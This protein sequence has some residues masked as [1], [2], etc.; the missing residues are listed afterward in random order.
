MTIARKILLAAILSLCSIV[1][2][3]AGTGWYVDLNN[4]SS[5]TL[6]VSFAGND[7]WYCNDFCGTSRIEAGQTRQYYTE[8]RGTIT[9]SAIQGIN[10]Q[11]ENNNRTHVEFVMGGHDRSGSSIATTY[12][13]GHATNPN[14]CMS[15]DG[16]NITATDSMLIKVGSFSGGSKI[17]CDGFYGTVNVTLYFTPP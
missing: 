13:Y 10:L 11:D 14:A 8:S 15:L 1:N 6:T 7:S 5:T 17:L 4:N 16:A 9:G 2:A 3:L 12:V